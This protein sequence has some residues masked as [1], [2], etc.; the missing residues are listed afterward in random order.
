MYMDLRQ[1]RQMSETI[2]RSR[3]SEM[4]NEEN[5]TEEKEDMDFQK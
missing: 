4:H 2:K 5:N 1:M 3:K